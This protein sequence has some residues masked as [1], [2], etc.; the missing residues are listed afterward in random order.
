MISSAAIN[1]SAWEENSHFVIQCST[2]NKNK[3]NIPS[4]ALV[5]SGASAHG[6]I[7]AKFALENEFEL[8]ELPR[9]RSL[10]VFDGTDT[11]SGKITHMAKTNLII[12]GHSEIILGCN[13]II[14]LSSGVRNY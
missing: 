1:E 13:S 2:R 14:R 4:L 9:P 12:E 3:D 7:N 5:D 8:I 6:F 11:A 10:K